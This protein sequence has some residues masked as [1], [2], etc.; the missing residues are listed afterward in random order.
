MGGRAWHVCQC[1]FPV[2]YRFYETTD[3]FFGTLADINGQTWW[4]FFAHNLDN[5]W[6]HLFIR[7]LLYSYFVTNRGIP[8]AIQSRKV[9]SP[10]QTELGSG[11]YAFRDTY[12]DDSKLSWK[13]LLFTSIIM[14]K[15]IF[16]SKPPFTFAIQSW[17]AGLPY[18][19]HELGSRGPAFGLRGVS[20]MTLTFSFW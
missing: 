10:L 15:Q 1:L 2:L 17:K 7:S 8:I 18:M 13:S 12:R 20:R 16:F 5:W 3:V 11:S 4:A 19:Q 6:E 9:A 14:S